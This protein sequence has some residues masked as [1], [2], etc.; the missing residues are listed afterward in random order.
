MDHDKQ[1]QCGIDRPFGLSLSRSQFNVL[2]RRACSSFRNSIS[3]IT[4]RLVWSQNNLLFRRCSFFPSSNYVSFCFLRVTVAKINTQLN[5]IDWHNSPKPNDIKSRDKL[6]Q[7]ML[8][9][10]KRQK[11]KKKKET[12]R[13]EIK[14]SK[15]VI[16]APKQRA[17]EI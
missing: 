14:Y 11:T 15:C 5:S 8:E 6:P 13:I 4:L 17:I 1:Y 12:K 16:Q 10:Q 2:L 3:Y 9:F 7:N